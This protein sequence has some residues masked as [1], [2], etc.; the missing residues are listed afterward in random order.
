[1]ATIRDVAKLADV[2]VSTVSLALSN[3]ARVSQKTL[4]KIHQAIAAVGS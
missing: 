3:P 1:M 4:E 2:S